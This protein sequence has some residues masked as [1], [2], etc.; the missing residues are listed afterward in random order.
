VNRIGWILALAGLGLA[1]WLIARQD[2]GEIAALL[3]Q[4]GFGLLL[5]AA[6]HVLFMAAN[7]WA[8]AI[9]MP[10]HARPH[11]G[12]ILELT[13]IRESV[14]TLL[15]VGRV[16]GELACYRLLRARGMRPGPAAGGLLIDMG[17]SVVAQL[18]FALLG[19]AA[20]M[21]TG[22]TLGWL[23]TLGVVLGG[24]LL[25]APFIAIQ[26]AR[27]FGRVSAWLAKVSQGRLAGLGESSRRIDGYLRRAW[28]NPRL[29]LW[30]FGWQMLGNILGALQIWLALWLLGHP[31]S[32]L[33]ALIIEALVQAVA[34]FA[35]AVPGGLG[36]IEAGYLGVGA[37]MGLEAEVALALA[38]IR[39]FRELVLYLPGLAAWALAERRLAA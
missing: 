12:V 19:L 33:E 3:G 10:R 5:V 8:W 4:A 35:F 32:F 1:V 38:L 20:L 34:A 18:G 7:G 37:L 39:R 31:V 17:I 23:T 2:L 21:A 24:V 11:M 14:N 27:A 13:W 36:V 6:A 16:G 29:L 26:N 28:R 30:S 22:R 25:A 15:P 9:A